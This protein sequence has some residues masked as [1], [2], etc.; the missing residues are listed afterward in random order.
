[1]NFQKV[2][3]NS[4]MNILFLC[5]RTLTGS[6]EYRLCT[7]MEVQVFKQLFLKMDIHGSSQEEM[8]IL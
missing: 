4:I 2:N 8:V 5:K 6:Q 3:Y 1:M 7:N